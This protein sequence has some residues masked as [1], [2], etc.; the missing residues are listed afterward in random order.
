VIDAGVTS[1]DQIGT[2]SDLLNQGMW[3]P[4]CV[5]LGGHRCCEHGPETIPPVGRALCPTCRG[6]WAHDDTG[7]APCPTCDDEGHM[8]AS[9]TAVTAALADAYQQ[10]LAVARDLP[11]QL[12]AVEELAEDDVAM[13]DRARRHLTAA[14]QAL[15]AINIDQRFEKE[16]HEVGYAP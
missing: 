5:S 14:A 3:F 13:A 6:V 4:T 11:L 7:V 1:T 2:L 12:V 10:L 9:A 15:G 8:P 16:R